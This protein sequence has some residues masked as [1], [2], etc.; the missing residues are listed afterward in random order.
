MVAE[1]PRV[2]ARML[3]DCDWNALCHVGCSALLGSEAPA[4]VYSEEHYKHSPFN[5]T[6]PVPSRDE[7]SDETG[8]TKHGAEIQPCEVPHL[9]RLN[10]G[11]DAENAQYVED[12][13]ADDVPYG[14][15]ALA[16]H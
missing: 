1:A 6:Q 16:S 4:R 10:N 2:D 8:K 15:V 11:S 14:D 13:A 3:P 9:E 12:V 5:A 7:D